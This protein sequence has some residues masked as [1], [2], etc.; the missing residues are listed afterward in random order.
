MAFDGQGGVADLSQTKAERFTCSESLDM[1]H[2]LRRESDAVVVGRKTVEVDDCTLTVRRVPLPPHR[3][4]PLRVVVDPHRQLNV[5]QYQIATDGLETLIY[6]HDATLD[7]IQ[8]TTYSSYKDENFPNVLWIGLPSDRKQRQ[9]QQTKDQ[10]QQCSRL[11]A[12]DILHDLKYH[13]G[14]DHIMIEGGPATVRQFLQE[15][16][17]DRAIL[18]YAPIQ[19]QIPVPSNI[20]HGTLQAAGLKLIREG[21]LGVD[22]VE[23]WS[24]P[25]LAW[26]RLSS[27][28]SSS[29]TSPRDPTA[30]TIWP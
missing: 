17:V 7:A 2:R 12:Q 4:Q 27:K 1:V 18:V 25:G 14:L 23:Y 16:L 22:R 29:S 9:Q 11:S 20:T 26:P 21:T 3:R 5:S 24:R 8:T 13:Q 10:Q 30:S 15:R 28:S 6:S 19:F